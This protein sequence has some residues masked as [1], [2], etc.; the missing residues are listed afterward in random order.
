MLARAPLLARPAAGFVAPPDPRSIGRVALGRQLIAGRFLFAGRLIE[1]PGAA[2]FD[3]L[4]PDRDY[5]DALQ[6]FGW[7]DDLAAVGDE[8]AQ[9]CAQ[10]WTWDWIGRHATGKGPGWTPALTGRRVL[11]WIH[12]G[13]FLLE[14]RDA[15]E[16]R[17]FFRALTRQVR[18]LARRGHAAPSGLPRIEAM[19]ALIAARLSLAGMERRVGP[20]M[21]AI[22]REC[23]S[24][25]DADGGIPSRCPEE[26]LEMFSLLVWSAETLRAASRQPL[27]QHDAAIGRMARTLRSLRHADGGLA[28]FHGGGR[29][30]DGRLDRA[31][32]SSGVRAAPATGLAMGYARLWGGRTT[33]IADAADPPA[34]S[35][36]SAHA[37]T[38]AFELTSG[39]RPVIV[40][41]GSG[42]PFGAEWR[43]A[44]RATAS[45]STL[46]IDG[47]SSSRLGTGSA[48]RRR[49][50]DLLTDRARV[51]QARLTRGAEGTSLALAHDGWVA[52]HGLTHARELHLAANGRSLRGEDILGA[53]NSADHRRLDRVLKDTGG[54]GL[55]FALRFHLHPDVDARPDPEAASVLLRLKSG[56]TWEFR[57]DGA[58]ELSVEPSVYLEKGRLTPRAT[59]Q[60]VLA[61]ALT[62]FACQ[63]DWTLAKTQDTPL[64]IRDLDREALPA[65]S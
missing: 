58:A 25:I 13:D 60:I 37:S 34:G 5:A 44:G 50:P 51:T 30:I 8:A 17:A 20:A 9:R 11:R 23:A 31:L 27:P 24:A 7:L 43:R 65:G 42:A 10:D 48:A 61:A 4:P 56:E 40:S 47:F 26:L 55:R 29:G 16:A 52:T 22:D 39:R 1:A 28:R 57:H 21:A 19:T 2:L 45:H 63:I 14:G 38:L 3:I 36:A 15:P 54:A 46:A 18:F 41:C 12:H 33:V 49:V 32:A 59:R 35:A 62:D 64:A 6:G 53:L